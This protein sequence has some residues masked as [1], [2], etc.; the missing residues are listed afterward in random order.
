LTSDRRIL[1]VDFSGAAAAGRAIW[2]AEGKPARGGRLAIRSCMPALDLPGGSAMRSAALGG[3]VQHLSG[4]GPAVV[5]CDFPFSLPS[6]MIE[7]ADWSSFVAAFPT[8]FRSAEAFRDLCRSQSDGRELK[9]LCDVEA[10]V[11]FGAWNLRLYRQTW[12][13]IAGLLQPL[14]AAE[15]ISVPPVT[16]LHP[17][18]AWLVEIC[19]A[20]F[21]KR[22]RLYPSYKGRAP[23]ARAARLEILQRLA[24]E[25]LLAPP[26]P[27]LERRLVD[28]IGGDALDAVIAAVITWRNYRDGVLAEGPRSATEALEG[29]VYF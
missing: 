12:H 19:P 10:K 13:G 22:L 21:L 27:D 4:L 1:G 14:L 15:A 18:R 5:G 16:P 23:V 26:S 7:A 6:H 28:D 29:R 24:T 11:P 8:R 3:L 25:R 2:I 9:R 20:S 17:D